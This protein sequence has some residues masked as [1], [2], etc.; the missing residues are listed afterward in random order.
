MAQILRNNSFWP[1]HCVGT[2]QEV[3]VC[4]LGE[5]LTRAQPC[6]HPD[7]GLM[8]SRTLKNLEKK[9][10][11]EEGEECNEDG[12]EIIMWSAKPKIFYNLTLYRRSL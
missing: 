7:L 5:G 10:E 9:E 11:E 3:A 1:F 6:W 4:H 8:A 2:Q 12:T